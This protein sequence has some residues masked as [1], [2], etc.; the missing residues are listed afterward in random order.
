M[1]LLET[2]K[3]SIAR[4]PRRGG[5]YRADSQPEVLETR[6]LLS[7]V[8]VT[9]AGGDLVVQGDSNN[10]EIQIIR[11]SSR[12]VD[13]VGL[14]GTRV[15]GSTTT[16][17]F[18]L[19]D[20]LRISLTKGGNN[21]VSVYSVNADD[22]TFK[23]GHG[24]DWLGVF[25][26]TLNNASVKTSGGADRVEFRLGSIDNLS[27]NTGHGNDDIGVQSASITGNLKLNSGSGRDGVLVA[28]SSVGGS[29]SIKTGSGNDA[30]FLYSSAFG[31][32]VTAK[33]GHG[34]D[35]AWVTSSSLG[36]GLN[37]HAGGGT[38]RVQVDSNN[39]VSGSRTI[40]S[41][42][43]NTVFAPLDKAVVLAE[44]LNEIF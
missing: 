19:S 30:L 7:N 10:N 35:E 31:G 28:G 5:Q 41:E 21:K 26:G 37:I 12:Q 39:Q 17:R 3:K 9:P 14:N 32:R 42:E 34:Q 2:L 11:Y 23:S 18:A 36:N 6:A 44:R 40:K 20:D 8:S 13:V 1:N 15:N 38:D 24:N 25:S 29:T 43:F 27:I 4:K 33:T 22:L 16:Q